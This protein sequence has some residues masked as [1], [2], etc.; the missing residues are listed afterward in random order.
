MQL[1][2]LCLFSLYKTKI[3]TRDSTSMF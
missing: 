1:V 3:A 2:S